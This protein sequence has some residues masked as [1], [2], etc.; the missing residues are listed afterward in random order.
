MISGTIGVPAIAGNQLELY[1]SVADVVSQLAK[2]IRRAR[3]TCF[4]EFYIWEEGGI[5]D[6]LIAPLADA[7]ERGVD[8]R[9]LVDDVGSRPFLR[10]HSVQKLRRSGVRVVLGL[11]CRHFA[12][13]C[14]DLTCGCI[15]RSS[16]SMS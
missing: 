9:L 8:C 6:S 4:L 14:S 13:F 3:R 2:D 12:P 16:S 11:T 5:T 7:A 1:T 10:S 15:A